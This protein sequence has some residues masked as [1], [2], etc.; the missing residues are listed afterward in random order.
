MVT[1]PPGWSLGLPWRWWAIIEVLRGCVAS[2][3]GLGDRVRTTI[4]ATICALVLSMEAVGAKSPAPESLVVAQSTAPI[5][6]NCFWT[7]IAWNPDSDEE[8]EYVSDEYRGRTGKFSGTIA[9]IEPP[10]FFLDGT[11]A[12][13]VAVAE[14][15]EASLP[16]WRSCKTYIKVKAPLPSGCETGKS[17]SFQSPFFIVAGNT[18]LA[19]D[20]ITCR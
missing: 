8:E 17:V 3:P 6:G 15:G 7:R 10:L 13:A 14:I 19:L 11:I 1:M 2:V 16:A 12:I 18:M 5:P 4:A 9:K 20:A